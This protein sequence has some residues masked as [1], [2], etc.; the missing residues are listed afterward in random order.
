MSLTHPGDVMDNRFHY[1]THEGGS[2]FKGMA[3]T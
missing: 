1:V 2:E 3:L